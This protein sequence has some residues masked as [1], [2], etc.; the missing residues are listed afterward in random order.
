MRRTGL[1]CL[2]HR[3]DAKR[4]RYCQTLASRAQI[5]VGVL[6]DNFRSS[7]QPVKEVIV[8][9]TVRIEETAFPMMDSNV[10]TEE[11]HGFFTE[12]IGKLESLEDRGGAEKIRHRD[13]STR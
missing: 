5:A 12:K 6:E 4:M 10:R 3:G 9:T 13:K 2:G 8:S 1:R 7:S 11:M